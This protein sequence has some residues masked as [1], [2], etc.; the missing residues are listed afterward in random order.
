MDITNFT[1]KTYDVT[2]SVVNSI[3]QTILVNSCA[4][5]VEKL[6]PHDYLKTSMGTLGTYNGASFLTAPKTR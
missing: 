4:Q 3:V 5:K 6:K 1:K 2:S